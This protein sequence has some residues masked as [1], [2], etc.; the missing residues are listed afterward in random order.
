MRLSEAHPVM[1]RQ[2]TALTGVAQ[3]VF[4]L[5]SRQFTLNAR[6]YEMFGLAA[7]G[8][9][10]TQEQ[11]EALVHSED[12]PHFLR[13]GE[14]SRDMPGP[15]YLDYRIVRPDGRL[16]Y[17]HARRYAE[18]DAEGRAVAHVIMALDVT[19]R[20]QAERALLEKAERFC[21]VTALSSDELAPVATAAAVVPGRPA[22]VPRRKMRVLYIEDNMFNL[23]LLDE[24][25]QTREDVDFRIAKDGA[26]GLEV[27]AS[28]LPDVL[29]LDANLPDTHGISLLQQIRKIPALKN[30]PAFMCSGDAQPEHKKAAKDAGFEGYWTKPVDIDKVFVDLDQ[31]AHRAVFS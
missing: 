1:Q 11:T 10:V 9:P 16:V 30:T 13:A 17:L 3:C 4:D 7:S 26:K 27:A 15:V 8:P 25:M 31:I 24:V 14:Q 12:L 22:S 2:L 20:K 21:T 28:W 6:A 19:D 23:M 5:K 29:V 18:R